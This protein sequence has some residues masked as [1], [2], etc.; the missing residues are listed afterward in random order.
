MESPVSGVPGDVV[1]RNRGTGQDELARLP[2][3]VHCPPHVI[4]DRGD[5]LPFIDEPR[6]MSVEHQ[7]RFDVG[8][9]ACLLVHI[10]HDDARR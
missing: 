7:G 8:H 9:S 2:A 3:G 4:P 5:D 1:G 6:R 10:E